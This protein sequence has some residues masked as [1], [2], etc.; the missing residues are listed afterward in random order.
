MGP[1]IPPRGR[2]EALEVV[3][4][5][6]GVCGGERDVRLNAH[7]SCGRGRSTVTGPRGGEAASGSH[8]PA[9]AGRNG[10]RMRG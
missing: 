8:G 1:Y 9:V 5:V 7:A 2:H 4:Y 10:E 6:L 3:C